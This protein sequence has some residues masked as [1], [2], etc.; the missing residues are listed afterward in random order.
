LSPFT[1]RVVPAAQALPPTLLDPCHDFFAAVRCEGVERGFS[2]FQDRIEPLWA[3]TRPAGTTPMRW[4]EDWS[5]SL[6]LRAALTD[7]GRSTRQIARRI[8]SWTGVSQRDLH[9]LGHTEQL[10]ARLLEAIEN[11]DVDWA[12]LASA[13]G[14]ADQAHMI[15]QMK[16]HTGFTPEQL[17]Q[18]ASADEAFWGY[19]LLGEYFVKPTAF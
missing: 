18:R 7:L 15:R 12:G 17:R 10:Y 13:S 4:I 3:R 14:F 2:A 1:E 11:G 16:R 5:R 8:K 19:R 9:G 6:V